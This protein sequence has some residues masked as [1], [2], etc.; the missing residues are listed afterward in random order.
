MTATDGAY[1]CGFVS[2]GTCARRVNSVIHTVSS[3]INPHV[4][5]YGKF[6][7]MYVE[8]VQVKFLIRVI[9]R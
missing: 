8:S 2:V 4:A 3:N 9:M 5:L 7:H 1:P 6:W